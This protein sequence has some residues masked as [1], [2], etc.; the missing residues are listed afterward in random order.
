MKVRT[1]GNKTEIIRN[2]ATNEIE[3][4]KIQKVTRIELSEDETF[5][6]KV[7]LQRYSDSLLIQ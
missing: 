6:L 1:N 7:V 3:S 4:C 2:P 5:M